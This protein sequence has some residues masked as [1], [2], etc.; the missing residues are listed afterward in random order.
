MS[1]ADAALTSRHRNCPT[2]REL[3]VLREL[4][5]LP[6]LADSKIPTEA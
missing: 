5:L 1:A 4:E 6:E 3:L 2:I